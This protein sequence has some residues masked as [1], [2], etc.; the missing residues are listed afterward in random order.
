MSTI[1]RGLG[2]GLS[3]LI[4]DKAA[5]DTILNEDKTNDHIE[6]IDINLI[7]PKE[8]QPRKHFDEDSLKELASSIETHGII[9]PIILRKKQE[10]YEIVAGERRWR[11]SKVLGLK[12]I[13]S[14]VRSIDEETASKIS[15]IENIQRENL[16][17]IEE[18]R[19]YKKLMEDYQLKQDELGQAV[20]K[21]R[22][23][24]SNSIRLLG[25][26][27]KVIEYIYDGKISR[28]HGKVLLGIDEKIDQLSAAQRIIDQ[29]L[30]VRDTEVA[31]KKVK[32][33]PQNKNI[34]MGSKDSHILD[35]EDNLMRSLG[36]KVNLLLGNKKGKIEIEYYS[37]DDLERL[38][39]LL[40]K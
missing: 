23:Y 34:K 7:S 32:I 30:N 2:K 1:K 13:P 15:L 14:I 16:N 11:A 9:Q 22:A 5:V 29:G 28:G 38:I 31:V 21:S 12:E 27:E 33:K 40:L 20:G 3:A 17:P 18:A 37:N 4:S 25:L 8:D 35:L 26:D 36:T 39:E 24:I 19:A 10:K 6:I